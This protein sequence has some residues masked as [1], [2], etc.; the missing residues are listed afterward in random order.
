[1]IIDLQ[2]LPRLRSIF[3]HLR[4]GRHLCVDDGALYLE[5]RDKHEAYDRLFG[6]LGFELV[7]HARGFY[8]FRTDADLGKEAAQMVVFFFVL[9]EAWGDA[10]R[11][12]EEVAFAPAGH[13]IDTLPHFTRSSWKQCMTEAGVADEAALGDVVRRLERYGFARRTDNGHF[14]FCTPAWRFFD[15]CL[16]ILPTEGEAG[17]E[18]VLE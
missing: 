5:L 17:A 8:Y 11:D 7:E 1:M 12:L 9:V 2:A 15:L 16:E 18:P 10:G 4:S 13:R 14:R 6:G 3:D